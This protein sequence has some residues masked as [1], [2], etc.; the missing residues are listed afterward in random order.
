MLYYPKKPLRARRKK[1][2]SA[3]CRMKIQ[4]MLQKLQ[5]LYGTQGLLTQAA[6]MDAQSLLHSEHPAEQ[7]EGIRR[8]L[9]LSIP[10]FPNLSAEE[11]IE[12][13]E[14][15]IIQQLARQKIEQELQ[16]K[17][18]ET[19]RKRYQTDLRQIQLQALQE[20]EH[21]TEN[22][23]TLGRFFQLE[24]MEAIH[25]APNAMEQLRP[26]TPSE[27]MGQEEALQAIFCRLNTPYP[28]HLLLYGPPGVGKTT[29]ARL[30]LEA[31]QKSQNSFFRPDAPFIETDGS[32]LRWDP[33]EAVNPLLGS[34]HDPIFQGA[35]RELAAN[36]IP[37][38]KPGL[39]SKAHGG[40]LF[41]DEIGAL[42]PY[43]QNQLLKVLE[44]KR[45]TFDSSYYDPNQGHI[46]LY[47]RQLFEQGSPA[48]FILIGA[49]TSDPETLSP[50]LRSRCAEIYFRPL[51]KQQIFS[52][53]QNSARKLHV[54]VRN[55]ALEYISRCCQDARQAN[56]L[57]A[58]AYS[59]ALNR[60]P[61]FTQGRLTIADADVE[62]A[63]QCARI[64]P[65]VCP[66]ADDTP[67][68][69]QIS[70]VGVTQYTGQLLTLECTAFPAA[71]KGKG[72]IQCNSTA[73]TMTQDAV[74]N[75]QTALRQWLSENPADYDLHLNFI[76][77]GFVDGPSAGAALALVMMSAIQQRP[78]RQNIAITGEI[79]LH[80]EICPVGGLTR[81]ILAAQEAGIEKFLLPAANTLLSF[82][83]KEG[84]ELL[85]IHTLADAFPYVF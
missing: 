58:D 42:D 59:I 54:Q 82:P 78:L 38:P 2:P 61:H 63:L 8:I 20:L 73:G 46:P 39:V 84:F 50:A 45:V 36:G 21:K 30:A 49:T 27:V 83:P 44:D 60:A 29:C 7:L 40:I 23:A 28:Q 57:L 72:Q 4:W 41:I 24:K 47:I 62:T 71:Q 1:A 80:G 12:S 76:G 34:V 55:E 67:K 16:E 77:G 64:T 19:Y 10:N 15:E 14:P 43:L 69:G 52:I 22:A 33:R 53:L 68:I 32:T 70:G 37:E 75:A 74:L 51:S 85:P 79:S 48:D 18:T 25:L 66:V 31:I 3:F 17:V 65:L 13:L 5:S 6:L 26:R 11:R 9:Q 81:K 56:K 35:Q